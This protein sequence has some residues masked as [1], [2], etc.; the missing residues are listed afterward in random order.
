M[1]YR[2]HAV[3][4]VSL[5]LLSLLL[6]LPSPAQDLTVK[7]LQTE[8]RTEPLG[9]DMLHPRLS[10][11]VA[12]EAR[13]KKQQ[14]YRILVASTR[15][16]LRRGEGDLWDSGKVRSDQTM[17][18]AYAGRELSS[19]QRCHWKVR[20]WDEKGQPSDWSAPSIWSIGLL[21][22][23]DWQAQW[24]G[25]PTDEEAPI[26]QDDSLKLPPS[27]YLRRGFD[28]AGEVER[29]T[30]YVTALGL[31]E[32]RLN[33]ERI[34][35][36]YFTPGWTDYLKRV[37]YQT[38]DVTDH[39]QGGENA[40][41]ALLADG[42]YAG[43]VGYGLLVGLPE[44]REMYGS[45]PA[46]HAQLEITYADGERETI[47]TDGS[48][49]A[50]FGPIKEADLLMGTTY[51]ARDEMPGWDRPGFE[52]AAWQQAAVMQP[53]HGVLQAYPGMP[54]R[55]TQ[56]LKPVE[57]TQRGE[58]KHIIDLGQNFAGIVRLRM[59]GPAGTQ[60]VL[61]YG[62]M[63]HEDGSL[64]TENLRRARAT[65]TYI[66]NGDGVETWE[67]PFTYHGFRY[68]EVSGYP[69]TLAPDD[70]TGL[71]LHSATPMVSTLET[72]NAM[73]NQLFENI[74]WTQR[75]NFVEVPT[76]C[77]QRDER[78]GWTGDTQI[79]A[80][81]ATYNADVGAFFT[82][83]LVD[84]ED[85][86]YPRSHR[87]QSRGYEKAYLE[88]EEMPD[89]LYPEYAPH[90]YANG[91]GGSPGWSDAGIIVP[92][93]VYRA[94]GDTLVL[95][96]HYAGMKRFM[97]FYE[98][99]GTDFLMGGYGSNYGDWLALD[100]QPSDSLI[101]TLYYGYDARLMAEIAEALGEA[102]D[103]EAFQ[104]LHGNIQEAFVERF[105][106]ANGRIESNT[107]T[108]YAMA[109]VMDMLPDS[110]EKKAAGRLATLIEESGGRLSVG[111]LGTSQ[112]LPALTAH[113]YNDLAYH[114][115]T[116]TEY[117]SWGYEVVN[118][119][120]TMWE[121]WDSYTKESGFKSP[122]MN[123]F[124]HY[125][126]GA[127]AEWMFASM[128]GIN[129]EG[130]GYK[131]I[132]VKPE[133]GGDMTYARATYGSRRGEIASHWRFTDAGLELEVRIPANTVAT[134]YVPAESAERVTENRT[135]A[136]Q[137]E[138]VRFERMDAGRAV[139]RVG[140]GHYVFASE[141]ARADLLAPQPTGS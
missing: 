101:A 68:V 20:V 111:F 118:G 34:G 52:D 129:T 51:D 58:G 114:L 25:L 76:D 24:I 13:A 44:P 99:R 79:F 93:T 59:E 19:R 133:I 54:V 82:K 9:L 63:L 42:W 16:K 17:N 72:S 37:H 113:G 80:R 121:R 49:A 31:Y 56:E 84:L 112:V 41:G 10:W 130:P 109:V 105:V 123:S 83:W 50:T 140:S 4:F 104:T 66:L 119:A 141:G 57:I 102:E 28:V 47:A 27:P 77:P 73:V 5:W 131:E 6:A 1:R 67:P 7:K 95:R 35:E 48:W 124:N 69:G 78:L 108:A 127:V 115:L 14:A 91:T 125:A 88:P 135:P 32:M 12:S 29:A 90:P 137:A 103:A 53:E 117:P 132:I 136:S 23:S 70:L 116:S 139:Y 2:E 22:P 75:S 138:G 36:D 97:D 96:K 62:E 107:Q 94:Y 120:T 43:Y 11:Q 122:A 110:L 87:I 38:Y 98:R 46:L 3:L 26:A 134:V 18:V 21:A 15:E 100:A 126:F 39:V 128:A 64:M 85:A 45:T 71:V 86:Q 33:G 55:K 106:E 81:S 74:T 65:D 30:L 60:V 89:G 40:L 61:R 92:Y 8:Y